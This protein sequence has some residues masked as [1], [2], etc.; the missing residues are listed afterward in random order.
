MIAL[1]DRVRIARRFQR[2]IRIDSDLND[3]AALDGF[4]C[5][6]SS[7]TVLETMV[8]HVAESGQGAFT[9]TGP[10]GSGKSSL[11]VAFSAVLNGDGKLSRN[12]ASVLG[13]ETAELI[14]KA[15]P[16]QMR[17]WRILPVVGRRDRPA[18]V[19]GDAITA[20]NFL[21]RQEPRSWTD[22]RV[23]DALDEIASRNPQSDGGLIVF[24]D[25][26]G[27]F[28]EAAAHDG[29]DI[30]L[31]QELAERASRSNKRLIVVGILHQAFEEYAHRLS[32][33]MRDEWS[34]IQGRFVDLAVNTGGDE[35]LDLLGRAIE[36]DH[37]PKKPG[38]LAESVAQLTQR[39]TSPYFAEMLEDC[40]PLHPIV[41]CLLDAISRRRFGQN[42]RSIFGF[43][44]S[45][46]P[47][48]FQHFLRY[49]GDSNIYCPDR[50]WDY[51]RINL[52]PS[53]LASTDG[54]RWA[55]AMDALERCEARGGEDLHLRLLKVIAAVDMFKDRSGLCVSRDL[56]KL[57]LPVHSTEEITNTLA[58]LKRWS[59]IIYR[60]FSDSYSIFEGSDFNI[61]D[62][63]EAALD[64][65]GEVDFTSLTAQAGHQPIVAKRHYHKTGALRWFDV[66]I[67]PLAEVESATA[68]YVPRDGAI[69]CFFLAIP[70]QSESE[71]RAAEIRRR[72]AQRTG[73]W[74]VVVGLSQQAWG[75][76]SQVRELLALEQVRDET[77]EL[78]G[79]RVARIEVQAGI[80]GLREQLEGEFGRAF[81]SALW[82]RKDRIPKLLSHGELNSLASDLADA[83]FSSAPRLH[84]E[85]LGRM[86]P[87]SNAVA[88][89]NVLLREMV[90][91]EGKARLGIRGFPAAGG[92]FASLL[93]ATRLYSEAS[94]SW[95]F[96]DPTLEADDPRNLAPAW[97]AAKDMLKVNAHR[98]VPIAEIYQIW[99]QEPFGIKDGLLPVLAVAFLLSQRATLAIYRESIF[100]PRVS[101]L[102]ID[103]LAKDPTAIQ[104]RWMDLSDIS[105]RLLSEMADI[106]R[107]L[108]EGN[109][110]AHLEPIDVAK[111]LAA[112]FDRLP[113]WV[114][115][116]QHLSSNAKRIRQLFKQANDPNRLI[117]DDIPRVLNNRPI[118]HE[119]VDTHQIADQ[120]RQGLIELRQA[121]PTMLNRLRET[122]LAELQVPNASASMLAELRARSMNIR[123]LSGDHRLEA[124]IVRLAQFKGRDEDIEGL[125][126]MSVHKP[127][128]NWVDPDIDRAAVEL[129]R[130]AQQFLRAEAFA[131]VKGRQ[132]KRHAMAV[133]VGMGGRPTPVHDEFDITDIDRS[134]V[135]SL[136]DLMDTTLRESGEGRR[137]IILA[138]LAELSARYLDPAA[139][140]KEPANDTT[141]REATS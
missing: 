137:N 138:A 127:T 115:R 87:S 113:P 5:P 63:V 102:D 12:A 51:L 139:A 19:I 34:K 66:I 132:D 4:I 11:V 75:I 128:W 3:T 125:A 116:T 106:V 121:Y 49:A 13:R 39:Q 42:Q 56:L 124:F 117:F 31:F 100:Q 96:V 118:T 61:D 7:A 98:A 122:L 82:Y 79:D 95:R 47:Q 59:F 20:T 57:A 94:G 38:P 85:L 101:D 62:A 84:N 97:Q 46:E 50:L 131:R 89:Q 29:A 91:N 30:Y 58:D 93:E 41:A 10:Y 112:I 76:P 60:K 2:S 53:I 74:D 123:E 14:R 78:Q 18:Q 54:H 141:Q 28:L 136:I 68:T 119:Q 16:P 64:S 73:S 23:L 109:E 104:L 130:M 99:R 135:S 21:T 36:S 43:L 140:T 70:T 67:V 9:W 45:A 72:A 69:G 134:E 25:E 107:E 32:R 52:E 103:Y 108:D 44:N 37:H 65:I 48:G 40:W 111:G 55:L 133:F 1:A 126:S 8:T 129:A 17:G 71:E 22:K 77:P 24:I 92:L 83:R 120:V 80:A 26:M 105:R 81:N 27:K 114:S 90:L 35:Q 6:R 86:K 88:A 33:E 15:L 110:L